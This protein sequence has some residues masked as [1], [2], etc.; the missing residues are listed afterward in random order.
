MKALSK[1]A[2]LGAGA[3]AAV[4]LATPAAAAGQTEALTAAGNASAAT[5]VHA[6]QADLAGLTAALDITLITAAS[7]QA[8]GIG[9]VADVVAGISGNIGVALG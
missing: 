3:L 1:L 9:V 5:Y 2:A 8:C 4:A 7:V 6:D